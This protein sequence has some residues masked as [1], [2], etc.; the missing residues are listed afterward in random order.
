MTDTH[1]SKP[2][3]ESNRWCRCTINCWSIRNKSSEILILFVHLY[4]SLLYLFQTLI[5]LNLSENQMG[6]ESEELL[7]E[8]LEKRLILGI[9]V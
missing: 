7:S 5:K 4:I 1:H 6:E 3:M 2:L 8:L 9:Y